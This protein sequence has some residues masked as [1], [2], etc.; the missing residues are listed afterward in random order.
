[1]RCNNCGNEVTTEGTNC[2]FCGFPLYAG[3]QQPQGQ[4][5]QQAQGQN[6]Q[7]TQGTQYN[8]NYQ[9]TQGNQSG[10]FSM[11]PKTAAIV[12]YLTWIGLVIALLSADR[13]D[14]F[15]RFHLN[16]VF[17]LIISGCIFGV[18]SVIL[19][20]IPIL[21][22]LAIMAGSIFLTVCLIMGLINA[23]NGECKPL[24]LLGS[25]KIFN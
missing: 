6:Y 9:Q 14:P 11:D 21:G 1:M 4:G 2:P 3:Y 5:F 19:V 16:N 15:F 25:F 20:F 12:C 17:V 18:A 10:S 7:Q 22:W 13:S 8:Q 23:I 24:P